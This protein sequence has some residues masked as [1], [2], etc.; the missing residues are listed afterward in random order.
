MTKTNENIKP[1]PAVVRKKILPI[2]VTIDAGETC[3]KCNVGTVIIRNFTSGRYIN[4]KYLGCNHFP[5]CHFFQWL[6]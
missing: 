6:H 3:K 4:K 1:A 2:R 5:N